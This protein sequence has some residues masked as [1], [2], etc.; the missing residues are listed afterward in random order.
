PGDS[1][2]TPG[3][4]QKLAISD[5]T[6]LVERQARVLRLQLGTEIDIREAYIDKLVLN[7]YTEPGST[8]VWFDDLE[9][10]GLVAVNDVLAGESK[11]RQA[12]HQAPT[13]QPR[14]ELDG[15]VLVA[16]SRPIAVRLIEHNGESLE[17]LQ[18]MGFNAVLLREP[19]TEAQLRQAEEI[20]LWLVA[21]PPRAE[22]RIVVSD[23]PSP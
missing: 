7:A 4:W 22:G 8:N 5:M 1:Y 17:W 23:A 13:S 12:A 6:R 20:G 14:V 21:P 9:V 19:P 2:G 15:S 11:V 10:R 18:A 16:D 3:T